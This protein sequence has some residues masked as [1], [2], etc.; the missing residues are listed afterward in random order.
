MEELRDVIIRTDEAVKHLKEDFERHE[1]DGNSKYNQ[2]LKSASVCVES[3][4][5]REQNGKIDRILSILNKI[6]QKR[7]VE[8][9]D[10]IKG[11]VII[12]TIVGITFGVMSYFSKAHG[13]EVQQGC[14]SDKDIKILELVKLFNAAPASKQLGFTFSCAAPDVETPTLQLYTH[15]PHNI[16]IQREVQLKYIAECISADWFVHTKSK[17][18]NVYD[19]IGRLIYYTNLKGEFI[20]VDELVI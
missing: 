19:K 6:Q 1:K 5:I 12:A 4:H 2:L 7:F 17:L 18:V 16:C 14:P 15:T 10:I 8:I 3:S 20:S 13:V 11:V 9:A